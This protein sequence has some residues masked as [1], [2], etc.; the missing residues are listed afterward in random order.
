MASASRHGQCANLVLA[1]PAVAVAPRLSQGLPCVA[2]LPEP[3][4]RDAVPP[5]VDDDSGARLSRAG[6]IKGAIRREGDRSMSVTAEDRVKIIFSLFDVD[7]NGYLEE[8]DFS[9]MAANVVRAAEGSGAAAKQAMESAFVH[10]WRTLERELDRNRDGRVS[11]EEF[12]TCVLSPE[13][14]G[15]T[16][17]DFAESLAALGDPDGDGKIERPVFTALMTAIGFGR[18]N[19]DALFDAFGPD[20]EDRIGVEVWAEGIK[21]YYDPAK[22]G[23]AG[24]HLV[25]NAAR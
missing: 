15:G 18:P 23:I 13:R 9:A 11:Y 4:G 16:V 21:D 12:T 20:G 7:R 22:V 6:L 3:A 25:A 24:D 8:R 14:F 19:I 1:D 5:W 17:A 2:L 10:Y